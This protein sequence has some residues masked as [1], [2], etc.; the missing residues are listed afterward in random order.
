MCGLWLLESSPWDDTWDFHSCQMK[1]TRYEWKNSQ[2]LKLLR[3][4]NYVSLPGF[5][6]GKMYLIILS[7]RKVVESCG[8]YGWTK[9]LLTWQTT[10]WVEKC[11]ALVETSV[12][13]MCVPRSLTRAFFILR[14][15]SHESK[16]ERATLVYG[17]CKSSLNLSGQCNQFRL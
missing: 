5:V 10:F 15:W 13:P 9:L 11:T 12:M 17:K 7:L 16:Q 8:S 3:V 1:S 2:G 4:D 6:E 14:Y